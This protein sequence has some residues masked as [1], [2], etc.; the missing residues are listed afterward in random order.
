[1]STLFNLIN[2]SDAYTFY[3]PDIKV[4]GM[5]AAIIS[6]KYGASPVDGKG[7]SSPVL[8]G[9]DD[10]MSKNGIDTEWVGANSL[11]IADALDSLLIGSP[12]QRKELDDILSSLP[13]AERIEWRANRQ[14]ELQTSA[15]MIAD[16]AYALAERLRQ[17]V[18]SEGA[19]S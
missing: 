14:R 16:R 12:E 5:A 1:M 6:S 17:N 18:Q 10:W 7:E 8:L 2:P 9:W 3:A 13:E 4:A 15:N 11:L 19:A